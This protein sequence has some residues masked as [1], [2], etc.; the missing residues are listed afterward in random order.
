M[1]RL[2]KEYGVRRMTIQRGGTLNAEFVRR[3]LVD[4]ISLVIAPVMVGGKNT[5]TI[6]DG[7]SLHK[8]SEISKLKALRLRAVKKLKHSYLHLYYDVA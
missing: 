1:E 4:H 8:P 5:S 6:M 7:E 2:Y 3:G